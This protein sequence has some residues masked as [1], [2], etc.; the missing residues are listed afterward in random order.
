MDG[1]TADA[2]GGRI[3]LIESEGSN[4]VDIEQKLILFGINRQVAV[5]IPRMASWLK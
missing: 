1:A 5:N 2:K 4:A 3:A